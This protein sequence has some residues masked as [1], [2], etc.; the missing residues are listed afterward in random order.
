MLVN[1]RVELTKI[2][3]NEVEMDKLVNTEVEPGMNGKLAVVEERCGAAL[4]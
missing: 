2:V 3:K 1:T 4:V